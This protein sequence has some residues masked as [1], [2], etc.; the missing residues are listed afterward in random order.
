MSASGPAFPHGS[1]FAF[2]LSSSTCSSTPSTSP[3]ATT[4]SPSSHRHTTMPGGT[5]ARR[6]SS[7]DRPL[8]PPRWSSTTASLARSSR[9]RGTAPRFWDSPSPT[10]ACGPWWS[11]WSPSLWLCGACFDPWGCSS[12][13]RASARWLTR[14]WPCNEAKGG[15]NRDRR[16]VYSAS[17]SQLTS[18][19]AAFAKRIKQHEQSKSKRS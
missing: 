7:S 16:A 8:S 17:G 4:S 14:R 12:R 2:P 19:V 3:R 15:K 13:W 6:A 5:S 18:N 10:E 1:S 9:C 11:R